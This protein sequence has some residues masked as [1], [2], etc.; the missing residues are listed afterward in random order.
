M[1][2]F[3]SSIKK[4]ISNIGRNKHDIIESDIEAIIP[5]DNLKNYTKYQIV[6]MIPDEKKY[7][8]RILDD[9]E[10][11]ILKTRIIIINNIILYFVD[12]YHSIILNAIKEVILEKS[13][14]K[15][16]NLHEY[17]FRYYLEKMKYFLHSFSMSHVRN[18]NEELYGNKI[19]VYINV[20]NFI[21]TNINKDDIL[22]LPIEK[23]NEE[24]INKILENI[25]NK[26]YE[27]V[28]EQYDIEVQTKENMEGVIK[29]G[30]R[31]KKKTKKRRNTKKYTKKRKNNII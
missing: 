1:S 8:R 7:N 30:K 26:V 16:N 5:Y 31:S 20:L 17:L 19:Q 6:Q 4:S 11:E 3:Y 21:I 2:G 14:L 24:N 25:N 12:I 27:K 18:Y 29:G 10:N 13:L 22:L 9:P 15:K 23:S 28:K